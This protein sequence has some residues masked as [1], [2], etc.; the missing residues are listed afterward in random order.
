M[1]YQLCDLVEEKLTI[2]EMGFKEKKDSYIKFKSNTLY[3]YF[4]IGNIVKNLKSLNRAVDLEVLLNITIYGETI[5]NYLK[6]I[7]TA[8]PNIIDVYPPCFY[9]CFKHYDKNYRIDA[10]IIDFQ[11]NNDNSVRR[12]FRG[13]VIRTTI[14]NDRISLRINIMSLSNLNDIDKVVEKEIKQEY[15]RFKKLI[16]E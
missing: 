16:L 2:S 7:Y 5:L 10:S 12:D 3:N 6:R 1:Y 11:I 13:N 9:I 8:L 4:F 15:K 14:N